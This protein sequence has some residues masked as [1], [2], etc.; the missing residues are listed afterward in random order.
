ML[1]EFWDFCRPNSIRTLPYVKAWHERYAS[2]GLRVIG[3]HCPGFAPSHPEQA[4]RDAVERLEIV[5]P[6]LIDSEF[7]V[8]QEYENRGWPAR[9]LFDGRARLFDYHYGEGAYVE[10]EL[11]IQELLGVEREPL[12]PLRPEDAPDAQLL[13]QTEEQPGAWSGPY[14]AGSVWAVLDGSGTVTVGTAGDDDDDGAPTEQRTLS[15]EYPGAYKLV[16][17]ERHTLGIL[18][19]EVGAGVRCLATCFTPGIA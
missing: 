5:H 13:P 8:W 15:V 2:D 17:H 18:A 1:V 4:V 10:T 19:L 3:V 6:V 14:G 12:Q 9:Y 16:E 11:A 7:E